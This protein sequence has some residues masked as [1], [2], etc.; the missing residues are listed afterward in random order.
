MAQ[1]RRCDRR[2]LAMMSLPAMLLA[3]LWFFAATA[4]CVGRGKPSLAFAVI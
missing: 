2:Q 1:W 3:V 4:D